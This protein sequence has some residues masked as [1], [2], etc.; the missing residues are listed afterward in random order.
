MLHGRPGSIKPRNA[1][2]K[3]LTAN[4]NCT[5]AHAVSQNLKSNSERRPEWTCL[6]N[7]GLTRKELGELWT[8]WGKEVQDGEAKIS[9]LAFNRCTAG[10]WMP[11]RARR[12]GVMNA[13]GTHTQTHTHSVSVWIF[14][15]LQLNKVQI[16]TGQLPINHHLRWIIINK[17]STVN[18]R[19]CISGCNTRP[20]RYED[21]TGRACLGVV[22]VFFLWTERAALSRLH[23]CVLR[24]ASGDKPARMEEMFSC[25][26]R[27]GVIGSASQLDMGS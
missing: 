9:R 4:F 24:E 21:W 18:I 19:H 13:T 7:E 1:Y 6:V 27:T 2:D 20:K 8:R 22:P 5:V 16:G 11:V 23:M 14:T 12:R 17:H 10:D 26:A 25:S 3:Y 15:I